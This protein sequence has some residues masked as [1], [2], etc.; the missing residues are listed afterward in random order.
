M[1]ESAAV[2]AVLEEL[3]CIKDEHGARYGCGVVAIAMEL[4]EQSRGE[5]VTVRPYPVRRTRP[6][7]AETP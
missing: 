4:R 5:G 6:W 3:Y 7:G 1:E 2:E